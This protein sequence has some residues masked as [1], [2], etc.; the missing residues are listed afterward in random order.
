[1]LDAYGL[2]QGDLQR[3]GDSPDLRYLRA[4]YSVNLAGPHQATCVLLVYLGHRHLRSFSCPT[5]W[6]R[7]HGAWAI[8]VSG[9]ITAFV[10]VLAYV[11]CI[12]RSITKSD[13]MFLAIALAALP[14]W[15]FT[16][17]PLWAVIILTGIDLAG[18]GPTFQSAYARP[19]YE[20]V[21]FYAL[22]AARN[23]LVIM[24]LEHHSLTTALFP[25]A[26]GIACVILV[27]MILHRRRVLRKQVSGQ[28]HR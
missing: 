20:R 2:D 14:C 9:V 1:M 6:W 21:G 13:W 19:D 4:V 15:Y 12:D 23:L 8:G 3:G 17:N 28:L 24:A 10:A 16:S 27:V 5:C 7:R 22:A 11:K 25:A 18:F 26:V